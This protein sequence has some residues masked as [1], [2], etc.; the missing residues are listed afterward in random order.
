MNKF[1]EKLTPT[2][3]IAFILIIGCLILKGFGFNG[4]ISNILITIVSVY[5]G[6]TQVYDPIIKKI[7]QIKNNESV[8][9]KIRR[10]TK[11]MG[12]DVEL[13]VRVAKC[14]SSLNPQAVNINK[15]GSKDRGVF[16]WNDFWHPEITD[17]MAFD[18]EVATRLF[19]KAVKEGNLKW[20]SASKPCWDKK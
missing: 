6:K 12:V 17:I 14:E 18:V 11:E 1:F 15:T 2:D 7:P 5:F 13:A 3:I 16:Q 9:E 10:I 19:C 20:W 4:T 8:E